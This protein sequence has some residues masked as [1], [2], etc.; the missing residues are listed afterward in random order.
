MS[1][2][3]V[4]E[5]ENVKISIEFL[6]SPHNPSLK[7]GSANI[8]LRNLNPPLLSNGTR[9]AIKKYHGKY[10]CSNHFDWKL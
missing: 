5:N 10:S 3:I 6:I 2:T 1:R 9:L 4:D 8:L 7:I